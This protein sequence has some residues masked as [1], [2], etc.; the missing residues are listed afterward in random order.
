MK[1]YQLPSF[2]EG[3]VTQ[4]HYER[5]LHRKAMAHIKRDRKRQDKVATNEEYKVA[6]HRAVEE[7]QGKDAYTDEP[8]DW[9]LIS[10]YDNEESKAHKAQYKKRFALLPSVDHVGN[11]TGP[12]EF[13][14]CGWRTNDAKN[15]LYYQE[16]VDLCRKVI[17]AANKRLHRIADKSGSR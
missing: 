9:T 6:I 14:I 8:L 12:T 3:V 10:T 16:F 7:S 15:D 2:L 13:K 1:K 17:D 4:A 5:W 11:E